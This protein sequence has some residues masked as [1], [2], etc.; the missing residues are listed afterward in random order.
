[1]NRAIEKI[2]TELLISL[3]EERPV[4]WDKTLDLYKDKNLKESA[5][6][7]ICVILNTDFEELEQNQRQDFGKFYNQ[8]IIFIFNII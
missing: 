2:D 3:V 5:W 8:L 4:I 6:K 1:M 7:E